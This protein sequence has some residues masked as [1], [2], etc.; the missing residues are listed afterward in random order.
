MMRAS[1]NDSVATIQ[2]KH[3]TLN[4][5]VDTYPFGVI[6][7]VHGKLE[8]VHKI[9]E[10]HNDIKQ[11]FCLGDIVDY[12]DR[13]KHNK[14]TLVWWKSCGIPTILGNHDRDFAY[15]FRDEMD[16][17]KFIHDLPRALKIHL[18]DSRHFLCYHSM[19]GDLVTFVNPGYTYRDFVDDYT[20]VEDDTVAVLIGHNHKQFKCVFQDT[21]TELWSVGAAGWGNYSI[22][23]EDGIQF[24]KL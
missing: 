18:P 8:N 2:H 9:L 3:Q 16:K 12:T 1:D 17:I 13:F 23:T 6:A 4:V 19:P 24:H 15:A 7:D 11:W 21:N 22:I 20:T 14:E 10:K 5:F